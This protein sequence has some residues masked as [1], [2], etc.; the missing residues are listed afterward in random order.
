MESRVAANKAAVKAEVQQY[1]RKGGYHDNKT[2]VKI[3]LRKVTCKIECA[4][5]GEA[6]AVLSCFK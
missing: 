5:Q 2:H 1:R 4:K 6:L 3:K